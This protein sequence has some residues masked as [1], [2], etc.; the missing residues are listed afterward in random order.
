MRYIHQQQ[1]GSNPF[2]KKAD[3]ENFFLNAHFCK[4]DVN[5]ILGVNLEV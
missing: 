2:K 3:F 1:K 5:P 4:T